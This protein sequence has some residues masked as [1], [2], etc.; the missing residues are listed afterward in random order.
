MRYETI[1][2]GDNK[3]AVQ[4]CQ[5]FEVISCL[6]L[7]GKEIIY[8]K[9]EAV[10]FSETVTISTRQYGVSSRKT[11]VFPCTKPAHRGILRVDKR[12][13]CKHSVCQHSVY[14]NDQIHVPTM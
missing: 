2:K 3:N 7:H 5:R 8:V 1:T 14:E 6:H 4:T 10:G 11:V 13:I 9:T 12:K